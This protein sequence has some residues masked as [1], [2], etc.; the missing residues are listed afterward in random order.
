MP[1]GVAMPGEIQQMNI[2]LAERFGITTDEQL[3]QARKESIDT[4]LTELREIH[5][6]QKQLT[7]EDL[8]LLEQGV[9]AGVES[10]ANMAP[11]FGLM[12]LSGGRAAPLLVT[13]GA[14]TYGASYGEGRAEGLT[15]QEATWFSAG[16]GY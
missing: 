2:D 4:M 8:N 14:Q 13:M 16:D 7:P 5:E 3:Q 10:L 11:G 9:R 6:K 12:L 1:A 15:T